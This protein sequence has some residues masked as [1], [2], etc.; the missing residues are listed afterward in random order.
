MAFYTVSDIP[1]NTL[2]IPEI[3]TE[4]DDLKREIVAIE[5]SLAVKKA[6]ANAEGPKEDYKVWVAKSRNY[7]RLLLNRYM[8]LRAVLKEYNRSQ[9]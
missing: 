9:K 1:I 8:L 5:S 4:I 2:S 6:W 7:R 3:R